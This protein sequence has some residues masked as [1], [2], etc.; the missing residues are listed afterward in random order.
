MAYKQE[1]AERM[2][3]IKAK[4]NITNAEFAKRVGVG[5]NTMS[6][7]MRGRTSPTAETIRNTVEAFDVDPKWLLG[8]RHG[9]S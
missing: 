6:E 3:I 2:R 1:F 4:E 8:V 9:R 5:P 7:Y